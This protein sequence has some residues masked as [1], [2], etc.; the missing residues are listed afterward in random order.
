MRRRLGRLSSDGHGEMAHSVMARNEDAYL[1][2][3]LGATDGAAETA[4]RQA[5][6]LVAQEPSN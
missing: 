6:V 5:Q 1:R 4:E 2:L 3:L